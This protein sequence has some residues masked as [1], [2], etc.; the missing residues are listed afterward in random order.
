MRTTQKNLLL[1]VCVSAVVAFACICISS[2]KAATNAPPDSDS[3]SFQYLTVC[4]GTIMA[5]LP[6]GLNCTV[7]TGSAEFRQSKPGELFM[8]PAGSSL[9]L[10]VNHFNYQMTAQLAPTPGLKIETDFA[11]R[12]FAGSITNRIYFVPA[13]I[14]PKL[15]KEQAESIAISLANEKEIEVNKERYV[16]EYKDP[17]SVI[18][19]GTNSTLPHP[20]CV[21]KMKTYFEGGHWISVFS[22]EEYPHEGFTATVELTPDGSPIKVDADHQRWGLP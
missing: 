17:K 10:V 13:K 12:F 11:G 1:V 6:V 20:M 14:L 19:F 9:R 22:K 21:T 4:D 16:G 3:L 15:T 2:A 7:Q 8:L 5:E 18:V